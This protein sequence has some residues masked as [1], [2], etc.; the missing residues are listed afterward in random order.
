MKIA[1]AATGRN[2]SEH[3]EPC[4][5]FLICDSDGKKAESVLN[6]G[7]KLGFLPN[8]L[9]DLGINA[10]IAGGIGSSAILIFNS[11]GIEVVTG[12]QGNVRKAAQAYC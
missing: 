3:F 5:S 8:F 10:L 9:A 4:E 2:V 6:P 1:V 12:T 11:R 7:H